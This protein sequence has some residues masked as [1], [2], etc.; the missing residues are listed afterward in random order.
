MLASELLTDTLPVLSLQDPLSKAVNFY[1]DSAVCHLPVVA[2]GTLQGILPTDLLINIPDKHQLIGAFRDD[3]VNAFVFPDQHGLDVFELIAKLSLTS[4]PVIDDQRNYLG[5][6][7]TEDLL[8]RLSN[9]YSFKHVGGIIVLRL[10]FRDYNL[11][12]IAH[13]VS[14]NN[15]RILMLYL[16]ADEENEQYRLTIKLDTLNLSSIVA[17]FERYKYIVDFYRPTGIEKEELDDKY[18]LLMKLFDL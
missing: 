11:S 5:S 16:D 2:E 12:E 15:A 3:F 14:G 6:V 1:L 17:T 4:I 10:G 13:I 8:T 7:I 9:Y 18:A